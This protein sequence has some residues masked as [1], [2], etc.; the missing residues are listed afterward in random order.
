M[1]LRVGLLPNNDFSKKSKVISLI[2]VFCVCGTLLLL[3]GEVLRAAPGAYQQT[4]DGKTTVWNSTP[5]P[6]DAATWF[7][8]RDRDGYASGVGTLTWYTASGEIFARYSGNMIH[9]RLD[10]TVNVHTRD[11]TAHAYFTDGTRTS[12]WMIGPALNRR[13]PAEQA[14]ASKQARAEREKEDEKR[15]TAEAKR[16]KAEQPVESSPPPP[17]PAPPEPAETP[18]VP[19]VSLKTQSPT[20]SQTPTVTESTPSPVESTPTPAETTPSPVETPVPSTPSA[21]PKPATPTPTATKPAP[22]PKPSP[23]PTT[24]QKEKGQIDDSLRSLIGPPSSLRSVPSSNNS[25]ATE[26]QSSS[27]PSSAAQLTKED[28]IL[29]ADAEARNAGYD[30]HD[31]H[32]P[33]GAYDSASGS[34]SLVYDKKSGENVN[35]DSPAHLK[36]TVED[37][38][39]KAAVASP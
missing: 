27:A 31:Y 21:T 33:K 17:R 4:K 2:R 22:V 14:E 26:S 16:R 11:K 8:E 7:G 23:S 39:K 12:K 38:T 32:R 10:G 1:P 35:P 19:N 3:C 13:V 28:A 25:P 34:W 15:A 18:F 6:G 20:A 24:T 36:I 9:G 29:L 30:L 5:K 37:E